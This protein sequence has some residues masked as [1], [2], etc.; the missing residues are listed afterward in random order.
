[1]IGMLPPSFHEWFAKD[2]T[3]VLGSIPCR[4]DHPADLTVEV[5]DNLTNWHLEPAHTEVVTEGLTAL[6][7]R[8][9]IS[10]D[11]SHPRR[12]IRLHATL[13]TP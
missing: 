3:P 12:F 1:M 2:A 7:V 13:P 6:V 11:A 9:L 4:V 10:L 5:S 8:D